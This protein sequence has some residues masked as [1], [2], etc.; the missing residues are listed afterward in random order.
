MED[1]ES[2]NVGPPDDEKIPT[3]WHFVASSAVT[4]TS[5]TLE[6]DAQSISMT[7]LPSF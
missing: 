7:W 5:R 1:F 3:E 2:A 4:V 6:T